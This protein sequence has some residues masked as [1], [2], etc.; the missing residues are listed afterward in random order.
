M[1]KRLWIFYGVLFTAFCGL[2][3]RIYTLSSG[4]L[5]SAADKQ[6]SVS[7]TVAN[8]RGTVYDRN[9]TPLVNTENEYRAAVT[10][11]EK[12]LT[13]LSQVLNTQDFKNLQTSLQSGRP[14]V[15]TMEKLAAAP[16]IT[17]FQVPKRYGQ[18]LLAP[19]LIG[20]MDADETEGLTGIEA[21]LNDTLS[22][23][24]GSA[25]VTYTV[26]AH[27]KA[28]N[29]VSPLVSNTITQSRGGVQLTLDAEIQQ[30]CEDIA[31]KYIQKGAVVVMDPY[32]G[33]IL[34]GVSL[35]TFQPDTTADVLQDE[36]S[37]LL[38]RLLC[39][40]NCG[41]VFKI[42]SAAAALESGKTTEQVYTC[43]GSVNIVDTVFRC[44]H[45]LG[46]GSM[47]M[48]MAFATSCNC[49]FIELMQEVG[50]APL[51]QLANR[52]GFN[53]PITI[54]KEM[55]TKSA[56]LPQTQTLAAPAAL[57]NLSFGQG[58]LTATPLHIA[59]LV[60]TVVNDGKMV[61]PQLVK[62]YVDQNG[63]T[64]SAN[65]PLTSQQVFSSSTAATIRK[66][67]QGVMQEGGTGYAGSP[68]YGTAGA[69]TGTAET[70][71]KRSETEEYEIVQSWFAG[72]YP[73]EKPQYTIVVLGENAYNTD[74]QTAPV[75]KEITEFL[76]RKAQEE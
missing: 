64:V 71:W 54:V 38:N 30:A 37:P 53:S 47:D 51:W 72:F 57:A 45:R 69:K 60:S 33:Q 40:Y 3:F 17:L 67:M 50:A 16:G 48:P 46:H 39:S 13:A 29:G 73:A 41:S 43:L 24:A 44:H 76:Y 2:A 23:Y 11:D 19:H 68:I 20:Y 9:G 62:G 55:Q 27:G 8:S 52:L 42:V 31:A 1:K 26:D 49:Y 35:P 6:S 5:M 58:E 75:F 56:T 36:D 21:V 65:T 14:A 74:A 18:R 66:M 70:G 15:I 34:A 25:K 32:S 7:V 59:Q 12:A 10:S 63:E 61:T 28:L 4:Y 22:A